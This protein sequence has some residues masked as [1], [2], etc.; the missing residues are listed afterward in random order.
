MTK[1]GKNLLIWRCH[2]TM[3]KKDDEYIKKELQLQNHPLS[4]IRKK[5]LLSATS[6]LPSLPMA[7]NTTASLNK[8]TFTGY[9]DFG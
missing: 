3:A 4:F 8:V 1:K 7:Y 9:V 5:T 2:V 6:I